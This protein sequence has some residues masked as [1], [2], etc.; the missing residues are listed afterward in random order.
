MI[1]RYITVF[2]VI[3]LCWIKADRI[4]AQTTTDEKP[5]YFEQTTDGRTQFYFDEHYFLVDKFCQYKSIERVGKYNLELKS[6]DGSF[7]DYNNDGN[8]ILTGNYS[9][10][11]KDGVF[12]A[13]FPNGKVNWITTFKN[14]SA[15]GVSTYNYPDGLPMMEILYKEG[16]AYVQNFWDTRRRQ[17]VIDGKG[18]FEFAVKAEGYNEFGYEFTDYQGYIKDG[19]PDGQWDIF[20]VYP[21]NERG[22]AGYERFKEGAFTMGY[23]E[24][25]GAPYTKTSRLQIGPSLFFIQAENMISKNCTIDEN[26]DF[27]LFITNKLDLAFSPYDASEIVASPIEVQA[28]VDKSGSL[29]K[30]EV[31]KG[32]EEK[33]V[34]KILVNTLKDISYWIPSYA[35]DAYID[36]VL[37]INAGVLVDQ[38][39]KQLRFYNLR[40]SRENGI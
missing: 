3:L 33:D 15:E 13:Y 16:Q 24:L 7:T 10:G 26:Q 35:N 21:K 38:E 8:V 23:D 18:K 14:G 11:K 39:T 27:S 2:L 20:L 29:S 1:K 37:T 25:K 32:F 36:D 40:I 12:T 28:E 17:R 19:K 4:A 30:I 34:N 9:N 6:Y 31:V 22:Y 5:V